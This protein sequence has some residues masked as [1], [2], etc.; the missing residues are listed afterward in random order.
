MLFTPEGRRIHLLDHELLKFLHNL[1]QA[2]PLD[3]WQKCKDLAARLHQQQVHPHLGQQARVQ[4]LPKRGT[5]RHSRDQKGT[6]PQPGLGPTRGEPGQ[7]GFSAEQR[8]S[9]PNTW[10]AATSLSPGFSSRIPKCAK[11][12][13]GCSVTCGLPGSSET[14]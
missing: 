11:V 4:H 14:S 12:T 10:D 3:S 8:G 13:V 1:R 5:V 6:V 2:K 7:T 9:G